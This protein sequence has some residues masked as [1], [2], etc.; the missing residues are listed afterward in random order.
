MQVNPLPPPPVYGGCL[1]GTVAKV[2][3][4]VDPQQRWWVGTVSSNWKV[5]RHDQVGPRGPVVVVGDSLTLG[6]ETNMMR[7]L[8]AGGYGPICIDGGV[9]RR[10]TVGATSAVSNGV[11]VI[12]RIRKS[13]PVWRM[14][15]VRWVLAI[16]T[17]DAR[18]TNLS[19]YPTTIAAGK[20]AVGASNYPLL[21]V[22]VRTRVDYNRPAED[23]W[24]RDL[25]AAGVRVV[26]WAP[27]VDES[28]ATYI[29][30]TD[31]IH[32]L[33]AGNVLRGHLVRVALDAT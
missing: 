19:S 26:G 29:N 33:P 10:M 17:N 12:D 6:A 1:T 20:A 21:W 24:N 14:P 5:V 13:D 9:A 30:D 15:V 23:K 3:A 31:K 4:S 11:L 22:D 27:A 28:P 8:L 2:S 7:E 16:G 32:L 18:M 25:V